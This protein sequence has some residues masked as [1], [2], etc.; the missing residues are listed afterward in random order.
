MI[1]VARRLFFA[2]WPSDELRHDIEHE[3][4]HASHHSGGRV[5]PARNFH[6]TLAFLGSVSDSRVAELQR[7]ALATE[8]QPF[9]LVL[10]I[11]NWWEQQELLCLEP[12]A[13][14][15]ALSEWAGR[16]HS[17]LRKSGFAIERRPF[18]PHLTLARDVRPP[19][20][21]EALETQER[22]SVRSEHAIKPIKALHWEVQRMELVESQPAQH[23]SVYTALRT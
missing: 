22:F 19:G 21:V 17:A 9:E 2:L 23:G 11:I 8:V 16:L 12:I 10:Q 4:R 14:A 13:G 15:D 7:C 5:I 3:T 18:R 1:E 6:I 20:M